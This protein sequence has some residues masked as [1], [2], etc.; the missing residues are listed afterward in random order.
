MIWKRSPDVDEEVRRWMKA[1]GW[2][3][4]RTSYDF[5]SEGLRLAARRFGAGH[6]LPCGLA[7]GSWRVIQPSS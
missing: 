7:D 5:D 2:E 6:P 3:V 4:T 1:K